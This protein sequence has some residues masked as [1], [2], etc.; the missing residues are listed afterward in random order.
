MPYIAEDLR[1]SINPIIEDLINTITKL[2]LNNAGSRAG[3]LN[4]TITYL[5]KALYNTK[6]SEINEA[7]GMLECVKQEYYRRIANPYEDLKVI[8]NGDVV[9]QNKRS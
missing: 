9:R 5:I 7:I 3:V 6:Y 8:E 1:K 2:E 4:Y